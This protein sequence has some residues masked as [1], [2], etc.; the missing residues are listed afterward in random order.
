MVQTKFELRSHD[1]HFI[2]PFF[3]IYS[4]LVWLVAVEV[5]SVENSRS[6]D[7]KYDGFL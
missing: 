7:I 5:F 1:S 6:S 2:V 4:I 3:A